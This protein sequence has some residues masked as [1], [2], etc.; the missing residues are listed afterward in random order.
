MTADFKDK[1][2]LVKRSNCMLAAQIGC[3]PYVIQFVRQAFFKSAPISV[4]P[5]KKGLKVITEG[6]LS[7][8]LSRALT[9]TNILVSSICWL[10]LIT[11]VSHSIG[12]LYRYIPI[13]IYL[14][15]F[16]PLG[17]ACYNGIKEEEK[18]RLLNY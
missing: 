18:G 12:L 1:A 10:S 8:I 6:G 11:Q 15:R 14:Q 4:T 7:L 9:N 2:D 16:S 5:T 17:L 13:S 3:E